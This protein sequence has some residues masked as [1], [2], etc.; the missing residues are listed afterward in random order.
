MYDFLGIKKRR[1]AAI[2]REELDRNDYTPDRP[3]LD[4]SA[5]VLVFEYGDLQK[6]F[7][8]HRMIGKDF[9]GYAVTQNAYYLWQTRDG[10]A[11]ACQIGGVNAGRVRIKGELYRIDPDALT[12]IDRH[13]ENGIKFFRKKTKV[14]LPQV[15]TN[16]L[17]EI[18]EA[19]VYIAIDAHWKELIGWDNTFYRG[20]GGSHYLPIPAEG[21]DIN[22][23]Y[24][25]RFAE[26]TPNSF[27]KKKPCH[28]PFANYRNG[29]VKVQNAESSVTFLSY[30]HTTGEYVEVSRE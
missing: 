11:I 19:H 17:P 4:Q 26:F 6:G 29:P 2:V 21:E 15:G 7:T 27:E 23:P 30:D 1:T 24:L 18:L 13:R 3:L 8:H 14:V 20:N 28:D 10:T 22:R 12:N 5:K 25:G 16:G 9:V